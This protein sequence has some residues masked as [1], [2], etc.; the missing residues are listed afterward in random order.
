M[1]DFIYIAWNL[2]VNDLHEGEPIEVGPGKLM[3]GGKLHPSPKALFI[4]LG[5]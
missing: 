3:P 1:S 2:I 4:P 5:N